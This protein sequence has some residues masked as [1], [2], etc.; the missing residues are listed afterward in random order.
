MPMWEM[1]H[2]YSQKH[3]IVLTVPDVRIN[4]IWCQKR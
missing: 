4:C 3:H 2:I 1:R